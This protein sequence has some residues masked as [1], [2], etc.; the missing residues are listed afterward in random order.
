MVDGRLYFF[1]KPDPDR[2]IENKYVTEIEGKRESFMKKEDAMLH[3][4]D[5]G[6]RSF[7]SLTKEI[8]EYINLKQIPVYEFLHIGNRVGYVSYDIE[9]YMENSSELKKRKAYVWR[10]VGFGRSCFA[11]TKEELAMK[12]QI[13]IDKYQ[14]DA[15]NRGYNTYPFYTKHYRYQ[16]GARP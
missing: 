5:N 3:L 16:E 11:P 9:Y 13:E 2:P 6:V 8:T 7:Q 14:T 1:N 10:F 4:F 12:V 15:E